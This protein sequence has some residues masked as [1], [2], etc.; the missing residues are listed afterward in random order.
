[1]PAT[2]TSGTKRP[3]RI[4]EKM[5]AAQRARRRFKSALPRKPQNRILSPLQALGVTFTLLDDFQGH[6]RAE[7]Q[8]M[9]ADKTVYAALAYSL[10]DGM[11]VHTATVPGPEK[12]GPFCEMV[13]A[14]QNP[15]FLGVVFVQVDPDTNSL[16]HH[17]VS[18]VV[19]FMSGVDAELRL[20]HAQKQELTKIQKVLEGLR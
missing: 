11:P 18:F 20:V 14:L 7:K 3:N 9:D 15:L 1:M 12:I 17:T 13:L 6:V 19:P 2:I 10:G 16:M 5:T 8:S 4:E